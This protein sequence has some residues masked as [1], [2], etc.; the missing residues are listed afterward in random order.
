[1]SDGLDDDDDTLTPKSTVHSYVND[2][3]ELTG[4]LLYATRDSDSYEIVD[5]FTQKIDEI[6]IQMRHAKWIAEVG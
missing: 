2:L 1:M 3:L 4:N 6:L 5:E